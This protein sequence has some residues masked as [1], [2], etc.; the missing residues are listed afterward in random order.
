MT[1]NLQEPFRELQGYEFHFE[2][3]V[4]EGGGVKMAGH[5]GVIKVGKDKG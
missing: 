1:E 5:V 3:L 4:F 2:N